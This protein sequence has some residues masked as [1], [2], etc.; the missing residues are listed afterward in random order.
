MFKI[1]SRIVSL[2][3][4]FLTVFDANSVPAYPGYIEVKGADGEKI[5]I[6]IQGDERGHIVYNEYDDIMVFDGNSYALASPSEAD[7]I[8]KIFL[9]R[10]NRIKTRSNER[11]GLISGPKFPTLGDHRSLVLLVEFPN[12]KFKVDNPGEYYKRMLNDDN[13]EDLGAS[14]SPRKYLLENSRGKFRPVFDIAG[15]IM[16]SQNYQYYGQNIKKHNEEIGDYIGDAYPHEML[17]EACRILKDQGF[18]FS[19]YDCNGDGEIDNVFIFYAGFGEADSGNPNTIWPHSGNLTEI[20]PGEDPIVLDGLI[21]NRYACSNELKGNTGNPDGFGTFIHEFTHV[22]GFPDLYP[23]NGTKG[24]SPGNWDVMDIG[25][26]LNDSKTPPNYSSFELYS[27]GWLDP[28]EIESPG[29]YVL[30]Y[31]HGKEGRA[32]MVPVADKENKPGEFFLFENRQQIGQ[33][34]FLPGHGMLVWHIDFNQEV[35]DANSLSEDSSHPY[36]RIIEADNL[37]GHYEIEE[38]PGER[39]ELVFKDENEGDSFPGKACNNQFTSTSLPPFVDW[40]EQPTGFDLTDITETEEGLIYFNVFKNGY[41]NL[42][43]LKDPGLDDLVIK[44]REVWLK[45]GVT[46]LFD[47]MGRKV[48]FLTSRPISLPNGIYVIP[49]YGKI[50]ISV[51]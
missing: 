24:V 3:F 45:K 48:A 37:S 22:M 26:Y 21:L 1:I 16:V 7:S 31:L 11:I 36:V 23:L 12:K 5:C 27:F 15:P 29:E 4:C 46:P 47:L 25:C 42:L 19:P 14:G 2:I 20:N 34:S 40:S 17:V 35:W 13:F 43:S 32:F 38:L 9:S 41:E 8:K 44:G 49:G 10:Q 51:K 39:P 50:M 6:K 30:P 28:I 18:D 33:D